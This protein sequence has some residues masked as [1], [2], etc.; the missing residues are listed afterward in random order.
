[1][2]SES[3]DV[4][5]RFIYFTAFS[6]LTGGDKKNYYIFPCSI[7]QIN[8]ETESLETYLLL[9]IFS[10]TLEVTVNDFNIFQCKLFSRFYLI[11]TFTAHLA[12]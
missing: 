8:Y 7:L 5:T 2:K 9:K 10:F 11:S 4:Y 1:V 6:P 3:Y 12:L